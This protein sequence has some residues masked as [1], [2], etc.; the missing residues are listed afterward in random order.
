MKNTPNENKEENAELE[1]ISE[2]TKAKQP[3]K[4]NKISEKTKADLKFAWG[5]INALI[6]LGGNIVLWL[7]SIFFSLKIR[8]S[9]IDDKI[10]ATI[11]LI[12]LVVFAVFAAVALALFI[13]SLV[14]F[15][16]NLKEDKAKNTPKEMQ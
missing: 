10:T 13:M 4:R 12:M 5:N 15:I 3:Q 14:L 16:Q 1:N 6:M 7:V 8:N 9:Y 11:C 2:E